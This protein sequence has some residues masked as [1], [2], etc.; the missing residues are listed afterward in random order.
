MPV[1]WC[2]KDHQKRNFKQRAKIQ[3]EIP[4]S[5]AVGIWSNFQTRFL[6]SICSIWEFPPILEFAYTN[7]Q[8]TWHLETGCLFNRHAAQICKRLQ[9][10]GCLQKVSGVEKRSKAIV[11]H[12]SEIWNLK[13]K[14]LIRNSLFRIRLDYT[15]RFWKFRNS[16]RTRPIT[17]LRLSW[18]KN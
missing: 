1:D 6:F 2:V 8:P 13:L 9:T 15:F 7:S 10:P 18:L 5:V 17:R 11:W 12:I 4:E 3:S 14:L 16:D